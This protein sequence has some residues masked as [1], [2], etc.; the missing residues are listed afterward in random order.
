[1][2]LGIDQETTL[3]VVNGILVCRIGKK[4]FTPVT[5]KIVLRLIKKHST[6]LNLLKGNAIDPARVRQATEDLCNAMYTKLDNYIKILH[7]EGRVPWKC[8]EDVP[9]LNMSN[10]DEVATNTHDHR[11]KVVGDNTHL[12]RLFQLMQCR[13]GKIPFH[14][15]LCITSNTSLTRDI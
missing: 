8:F 3:A 13:D 4:E 6:L 11:N 7:A 12:G 9:P 15:T 5:M 10:M 2:G 1:M 14:I